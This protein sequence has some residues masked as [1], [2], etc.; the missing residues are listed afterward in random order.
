[1]KR[2]KASLHFT[3][4]KMCEEQE[5]HSQINFSKQVVATINEIVW[6]QIGIFTKDLEAFAKYADALLSVNHLYKLNYL[7]S[8]MP[9]GPP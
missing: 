5:V 7:S 3:V 6:R 9:R 4:G 8:G 2:L 1:M